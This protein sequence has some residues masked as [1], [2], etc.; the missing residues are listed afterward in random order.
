[1]LQTPNLRKKE[2]IVGVV[3]FQVVGIGKNYANFMQLL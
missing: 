1:M 2:N 3:Y